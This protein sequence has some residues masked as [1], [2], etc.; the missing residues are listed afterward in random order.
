LNISLVIKCNENKTIKIVKESENKAQETATV[1]D[2]A[3][4]FFRNPSGIFFL[5]SP[6][7]AIIPELSITTEPSKN[8]ILR[9][10][11]TLSF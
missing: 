4:L 11:V 2:V 6:P 8:I 10:F 9:R 5:E 7:I 1:F 3:L